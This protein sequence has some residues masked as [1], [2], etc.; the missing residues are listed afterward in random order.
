MSENETPKKRD[1][2]SITL[3]TLLLI[4]AA[5]MGW[6]QIEDSRTIAKGNP[7]PDFTVKMLDG[8]SV[9]LSDLK[10]KVVL[11]D[12][13]ATWCPP[14]REE[15]P[16]LV[17]TAKEYEAKGVVFLA[18]S[19]DDVDSQTEMITEFLY[20]MPQVKPY[21]ALG[22]PQISQAFKVMSLPTL[23]VVDAKGNISS[24]HIGQVSENQLRKAIDKALAAP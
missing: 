21:A 22:T 8:H 14:C 3:V 9:S 11:V 10:G 24:A 7:A 1:Y 6:Q 19:N 18:L 2:V 4:G 20:Q 16:Y 15:M 12:F 23:Y 17:S 13:W 5:L